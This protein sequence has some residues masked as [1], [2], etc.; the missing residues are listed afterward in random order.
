MS[1]SQS[2][3]VGGRRTPG[4]VDAYVY[5]D[6]GI[7]RPGESVELVAMLRDRAG[8]QVT[9]RN[10]HFV[11]Y[12][13]NG[14]VASKVRFTDPKSGAVLSTFALPRGASRGE[15]RASIEIYGI[16]APAGEVRFAVE[17][18]VPQRIAVDIKADETRALKA[19]GVRDVEVDARF[20]YGAP[21]AGLSV[22]AEARVEADP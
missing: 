17:D 7:Y 21:G 4:P 9:G 19:G 13:P 11:V 10:G 2:T 14:L 22:K 6:R 1:K 18:F 12:R 20:L 5:S 16:D 8:R 3:P 15:W